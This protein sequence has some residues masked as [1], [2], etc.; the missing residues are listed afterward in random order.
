MYAHHTPH[1]IWSLMSV[2]SKNLVSFSKP[3]DH[4]AWMLSQFSFCYY[5]KIR[6]SW[7]PG[8]ELAMWYF[9]FLITVLNKIPQNRNLSQVEQVFAGDDTI[10]FHPYLP[11]CKPQSFY[12]RK[13]LPVSGRTKKKKEEA[14]EKRVLPM[15]RIP[16]PQG[17]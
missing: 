6:T 12:T 15:A 8:R 1:V 11:A 2:L 16:M 17:D 4:R 5:S 13:G 3:R 10:R 9:K 7:T 14:S